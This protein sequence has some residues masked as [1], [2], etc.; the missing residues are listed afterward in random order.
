M[1]IVVGI[2]GATGAIYGVRALEALRELDVETHL[3]ISKWGERTI[4]HETPLSVR[5]VRELAGE[6]HPLGNQA[7]VISSGSFKTD[8]MLVAPC[9][10][11][12]LAA[13]RHGLAD[14]LLERAADVTLK[15]GRKL[16]LLAR[17]TPLSQVH[18]ENMLGLARM[19]AAIV[20]PVPAFYN[21]PESI[22]DLVD[23]TV[24]R[25]L[26]QLGLD[27]EWAGRWSGSL[28]RL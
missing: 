16:V 28:G 1:R 11:R 5:E 4:E 25:A 9:S 15:E 24:V 23:H 18:L 13:I 26:D 19:G 3:V 22:D 17:E 2:S 20:P 12:T 7:A 8:G 14:N 6:S 21:R 10:M 27:P